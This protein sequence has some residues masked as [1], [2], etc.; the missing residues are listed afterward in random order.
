MV[1]DI[2]EKFDF[3]KRFSV[4]L[5]QD[6]T[7]FKIRIQIRRKHMDPVGSTT[8]GAGQ[9]G[10]IHNPGCQ[11]NRSDSQPKVPDKSVG[12]TTLGARQT[13]RIHNPGCQKNRSDPQSWVSDEDVHTPQP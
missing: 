8:L 2:E 4:F 3:I 7:L 13:G 1:T 11:T 5:A 12:S 10:R 6:L 9:P